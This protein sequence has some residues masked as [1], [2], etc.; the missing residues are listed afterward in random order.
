MI[1][2]N[3]RFFFRY[4]HAD[5][6]TENR[7]QQGERTNRLSNRQENSTIVGIARSFSVDKRSNF[8]AR[9][10]SAEKDSNFPARSITFQ[11]S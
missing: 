3:K 10:V 1:H 11:L 7:L 8:K 9:F 5:K 4:A 6:P 2:V